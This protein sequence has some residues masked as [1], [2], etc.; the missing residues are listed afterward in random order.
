MIFWFLH[1]A[2][3]G[4]ALVA[5]FRLVPAEHQRNYEQCPKSAAYWFAALCSFSIPIFAASQA[6]L[7]DFSFPLWMRMAGAGYM[8]AGYALQIWA[9]RVNFFLLPAVIYVPPELRVT[10][11]PYR[12]CAHPFYMGAVSASLGGV[13]LLGQWW[14]L[15]PL[16]AYLVLILWR[17]HAENRILSQKPSL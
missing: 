5:G 1:F 14:A 9:W 13:A 4:A 8:V 6:A 16:G 12:Y 17:V 11:G 10:N 3:I 7:D 2:I 15:F